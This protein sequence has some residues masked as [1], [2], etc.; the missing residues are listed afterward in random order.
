METTFDFFNYAGIHRPVKLYTTPAV[1]LSD[2]NVTTNVSD[3]E[4]MVNVDA[5]V[6][7]KM[8]PANV[9]MTYELVDK[10]GNVVAS[11]EGP[12]MLRATLTV[13]NP[14]LWWPIGM[15]D[16]PGYLYDLKVWHN[17]EGQGVRTS[18]SP[19]P[20]M[21]VPTLF[22]LVPT[23]LCLFQQYY[24]MLDNFLTIFP[25][26]HHLGNPASHPLFFP[27]PYHF[28]PLVPWV[29]D[30]PPPWHP[31]PHNRPHYKWQPL[32]SSL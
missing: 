21:P 14:M 10:A 1:H 17:G 27:L 19:C 26:S 13:K 8:A 9:T 32:F 23:S 3:Q 11:A 31:A 12:D 24:A 16:K 15:S 5:T 30:C 18:H 4:A 29:Q 20:L 25:T 22:W 28:C 2:I 6:T 7:S